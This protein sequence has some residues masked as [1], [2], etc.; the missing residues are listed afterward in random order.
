M[1]NG[2]GSTGSYCTYTKPFVCVD[3]D[4]GKIVLTFTM[5]ANIDARMAGVTNIIMNPSTYI[6]TVN[7][8]KKIV[9]WEGIWNNNNESVLKALTNLGIDYPKVADDQVI[10]T[11]E[12]GETFAA[13][14]L[15]AISDGYL[16]NSHAEKCHDFVADTVSW[17]WSDGTK[18]SAAQA[19][20]LNSRFNLFFR[21]KKHD[22]C[23]YLT[24]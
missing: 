4:N 12:E 23:S 10:I 22:M 16:D 6:L 20:V 1:K 2:W 5:I 11:R 8:D 3:T 13:K 17:D 15:K 21:Q 24:T 18:V 9:R 7:K 14:Y 19:I